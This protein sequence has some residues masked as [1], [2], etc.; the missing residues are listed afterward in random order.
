MRPR[1]RK[2]LRKVHSRGGTPADHASQE[3]IFRGR[4]ASESSI[5]GKC[6]D[7]ESAP[8]I[9]RREERELIQKPNVEAS[10]AQ[11]LLWY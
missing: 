10:Q 4:Y 11:P 1:L 6:A 3:S 5:S 8:E 2:D 9:L 7:P